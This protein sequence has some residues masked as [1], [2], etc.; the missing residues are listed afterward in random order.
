MFY[1]VFNDQSAVGK[2]S[3]KKKK[4]KKKKKVVGSLDAFILSYIH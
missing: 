3:S 2:P 1:Q 4:K